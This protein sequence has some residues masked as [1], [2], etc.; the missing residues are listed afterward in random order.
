M[1]V[2]KVEEWET[3]A[4]ADTEIGGDKF[5]TNV[6]VAKHTLDKFF[7]AS[8]KTFLNDTGMGSHPDVIRTMVK[9]AKALGEDKLVTV[10]TQD[11][12]KVPLAEKFYGKTTPSK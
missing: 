12:G 4:K 3:A 7:P 8:I 9:I 2:K 10:G 1:W 11:G 5:D 6:A